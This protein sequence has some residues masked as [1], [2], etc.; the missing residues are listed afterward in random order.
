[1]RKAILLVVIA[2]LIVSGISCKGKKPAAKQYPVTLMTLDPGHF[3]A[4]LVQKTMYEQ[5]SPMVYVYAPAGADVNEHLKRIEGFNKRAENP[6]AWVEKVYTG[7]N[8]FEKMLADKPGNIVVLSGNNRKKA[9][10]IKGCV[11]TGLNVLADK[12]MCINSAGFNMLEDAF[13]QARK[14]K[15]VIYDIMTERSEITTI[16]QK[17]LAEAEELFGKITPG[18]AEQPAI[19]I[20]SVHH[21][22]KTVSGSPLK[23]PGWYFDT[24]QQGEGIV[25]VTTHLIDLVMWEC[26]PEQP[27]DYHKD[28]EVVKAK[29]LPTIISR[30]QFKKST[31]MDDFPDFLKDRVNEKGDLACFANGEIIFKIK[32]LYAKVSVVWNFEAPPGGQDTHYAIMRG[33]LSN[34]IIRQGKE[35]NYKPELYIEPAAGVKPDE[36]KLAVVKTIDKLSQDYAGLN[37]EEQNDCWRV[38]IPD[39]YRVGHEAHFG[40]VM[41]RFLKYVTDGNMPEWETANMLAKYYTTTTAL[42]MAQPGIEFIQGKNAIDVMINGN[43]FTTYKYGED[44]TKPILYP[45][46]SPSGILMT[47][48][49]PFEIIPGESNDHPHHFGIFFTYDKVNDDGFWNNATSPPQIKHVKFTKM[50]DGQLSTISQWVGKSGK[51]LLEEKRDMFFSEEPNQYAI[52]FNIVLTAQDEKIVFSDTKEGMFAIRVADWL[53]EEKGT[54]RYLDSNGNSGEPNVWGKRGS[55]TRL[56]GKN[57]RKT[58]GIAIINHPESVNYPTYWHARG[59]GLFSANPLG[60]LDY[61]KGTKVENPQPL[62]FTL[63]P[64]QSALFRFRII[65]YEGP[66]N[67]EQ[68][69]WQFEDFARQ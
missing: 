9:E 64:G 16:L 35:Q 18:S 42:K 17:A 36:L 48:R 45:V 12:P 6:T 53:S 32:G 47:R 23:R 63:N 41:E 19:E 55:W 56:E 37:I 67:P 26:F 2:S 10:Y 3:H 51:V 43:L 11:D 20:E 66:R 57:D 46:K 34:A 15:V 13:E 62:N 7:N 68:F 4:G 27:I 54:G 28:I 31:G 59:Y 21:F 30:E 52:D 65:I 14:S 38:T 69:Q 39:K 24:N 25:D 1:M 33:S 40:Q 61:Q 60:Q 5:V 58:I 50:S 29:R 22:F 44:L 49:F 8:F